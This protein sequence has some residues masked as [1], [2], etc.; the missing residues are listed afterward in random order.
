MAP[1]ALIVELHK[2]VHPTLTL[3]VAFEL[4]PECSI[5]FGRSGSG[6][7][8]TLRCIAGM[9]RPDSGRVQLN[10][11]VLFDGQRGCAVPMRQRRISMIFQ[12]DLLFP[13][14]NARENILFG[15]NGWPRDRRA[16]R[17][18]EMVELFS[19]R[20]LLERRPVN[21]S[22]GEKQRVGLAR[23][24]A[25][26]P[27]LLLCDEP[28][29]AIDQEGRSTLIAHL[30]RVQQ[31]EQIPVLYVT[32]SMS[33]AMA[34]GDRLFALDQGRIIAHGTPIDVFSRPRQ[35]ALARLTRVQN[36]FSAT[37]VS[38][39]PDEGS[40]LVRIADGPEMRVPLLHCAIGVTHTFGLR[41]D[42]ILLARHAVTGISA[43][44]LIEGRVAEI[45]QNEAEVEV[46]IECGARFVASVVPAAVRSLE[47]RPGAPIYM[48]I[49]A[50][51]CHLLDRAEG[52]S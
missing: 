2:Q 35:L 44:N 46:I 12:D 26:R 4:G 43:Q 51:S 42:D 8:T 52:L 11:T 29:S 18:D 22:G 50:R 21:L 27:Q 32:H 28:I 45:L 23:A 20:P 24:I 30:R 9:T 13:H 38:H 14:L 17:L 16:R 49:K 6:K 41:A 36:I 40:T 48:I 15:L 33:E 47:L 3:D 25:P 5:L 34:L 7:T 1:P 19:I 37:A 39:D 31:A 10:G